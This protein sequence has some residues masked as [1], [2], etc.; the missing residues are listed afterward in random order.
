MKKYFRW[1]TMVELIIVITIIAILSTIWFSSFQNYAK[2]SRDTK[3]ISSISV[4]ENALNLHFAKTQKYPDPSNSTQILAWTWILWYQWTFSDNIWVIISMP[5]VPKDPLTW[6]DFLYYIN[7]DKK[8]Y[9]LLSYF[10]S[11][12][13]TYFW[14][15]KTQ[16]A[17]A[18]LSDMFPKVSWFPLWIVLNSN[19]E[20]V[21]WSTFNVFSWTVNNKF[22]F[23]DN[24]IFSS[25]TWSEIF[26]NIYNRRE[27]LFKNKD[28]ATFDN[29]L[30]WYWDMET[31]TLSWSQVVLKDLSKYGNNWVLNWWITI[32]WVSW[33]NWKG[34]YFDWIDDYVLINANNSINFSTWFTI[35][36]FSNINSL[37]WS[38]LKFI[39][40]QQD[41]SGW[42]NYWIWLMN[43]NSKNYRTSTFLWNSTTTFW[44]TAY[45]TTIDLNKYYMLWWSFSSRRI[46]SILDS[47]VDQTTLDN[48]FTTLITSSK[49]LIIWWDLWFQLINWTI[50]EIRIYNRALSEQEIKTLYI[51]NKQ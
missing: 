17:Y 15:S 48:N 28:Y 46:S 16:K 19:N 29:S 3:R 31:T 47:S 51:W 8:R 27:D 38:F 36:F 41:G 13:N 7:Y 37:T 9:Q 6:N 40:K 2:N 12:Y 20:S 49:P 18:W 26:S 43:V 33:I 44:W 45:W 50:D 23:K 1:F 25:N 14:Y 22:Y 32:W 35:L 24:D 21:S 39:S 5:I 11:R 4:I 34:T 10:E 30:V 42:Y